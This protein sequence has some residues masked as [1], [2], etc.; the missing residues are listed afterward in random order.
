MA[1]LREALT[2][3]GLTDVASFGSSGN[4]VFGAP[5]ADDS[6]LE[7]RISAALG[8]E[9]FVR[10]RDELGEIVANDPYA[11]R[12]GSGLLI[13]GETVDSS[14]DVFEDAAAPDGSPPVPFGSTV[15][16]VNP[17]RRRGKQAIVDFERELG[18]R[19]TMRSSRVVERV[20]DML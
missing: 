17:T 20:L 16:F 8:A 11:G 15:Y 3:I 5:G 7:R 2:A 6:E 1:P 9:V 12:P 19:G 14:R 13:A 10:D 18:V 4:F